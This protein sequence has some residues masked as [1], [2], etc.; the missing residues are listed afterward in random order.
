MPTVRP[1]MLA[2]KAGIL[3]GTNGWDL[4][5]RFQRTITRNS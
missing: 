4:F 3:A 1:S 5:N 2:I